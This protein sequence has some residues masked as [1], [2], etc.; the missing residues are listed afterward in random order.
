[1][2]FLVL[3]RS[4]GLLRFWSIWKVPEGFPSDCVAGS[5][6]VLAFQKFLQLGKFR[7]FFESF[8]FRR[9]MELSGFFYTP[10]KSVRSPCA[11]VFNHFA[12]DTT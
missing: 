12:G 1:M 10:P 11:A 2:F 6:K 8:G 7:K 4:G 5:G 9:G 3:E